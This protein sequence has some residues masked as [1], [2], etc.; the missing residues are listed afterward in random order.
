VSTKI[1]SS[2][3]DD[4]EYIN[5]SSKKHNNNGNYDD[6]EYSNISSRS[7]Y[8]KEEENDENVPTVTLP[9]NKKSFFTSKRKN[10]SNHSQKNNNDDPHGY[11]IAGKYNLTVNT[12]I[13]PP[14]ADAL[15]VSTTLESQSPLYSPPGQQ[16]QQRS[17]LS[18]TNNHGNN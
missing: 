13:E 7:D 9:F 18:P 15:R 5:T 1:K 2:S 6:D 17:V 14:S 12:T 3:H 4:D 8:D 16:K 11:T 10:Q